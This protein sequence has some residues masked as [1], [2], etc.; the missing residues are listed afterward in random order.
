MS[1]VKKV[2]SSIDVEEA[3]TDHIKVAKAGVNLSS[4]HIKK[5]PGMKPKDVRDLDLLL[6]E[7]SKKLDKVLS[8]IEPTEIT[9][10]G[11]NY[12]KFR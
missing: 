10:G 12:K 4:I 11:I 6:K 7:F 5:I 1:K 2:L 9:V 8:E 3:K